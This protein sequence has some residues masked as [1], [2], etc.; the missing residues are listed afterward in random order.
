MDLLLPNLS[1]LD[2]RQAPMMELIERLCNLNSGTM[3]LEGLD[4]VKLELV[5]AYSVLG[6]DLQLRDCDPLSV[7]DESGEVKASP[8]GQAIHIV[9]RP[10]ASKRVLLCIHMD[11]VYD[12][13]HPFQK[14]KMLDNGT[15]NGPG[16]ADAKGGLVVM[17]EALRAFEASSFASNLGWEVLINPDEEIGSP[18]SVGMIKEIAQRCDFGLLFEPGLDATSLVSWRKG[19]G[20]FSF[21]VRGR[22]AHAGRD[23]A[24]GRNAI[25]AASRLAA[26]I[27]ELNSDPEITFNV[28]RISGGGALNTVPDLAIV[29]VNVRVRTPEEQAEVEQQ[30]SSITARFNELDG[31]SV[32]LHGT[33]SSPPKPITPEMER[34]QNRIE[35]CAKAL[36]MDLNWR[37]TGGASD[38]NKFAAAGL[39]NVDSLGPCGGRIHSDEEFLIPESLVP[40]AKLATLIL[41]NYASEEIL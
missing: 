36:G 41:L 14:C 3:N 21:V 37:G 10:E 11:T 13:D 15:F 9:K 17:L 39:P 22:A 31:I 40:R 28:G 16:V 12:A 23:F 1:L 25:T 26:A 29:R 27:D 8:L 38:G 6:G 35:N 33:F 18:G 24:A 4:R 2:D 30:M 20:N 34:V 7:V 32:T 5:N 19:S